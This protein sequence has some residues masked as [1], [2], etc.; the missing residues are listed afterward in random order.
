[1]AVILS[2]PQC[3]KGPVVRDNFVVDWQLSNK[4]AIHNKFIKSPV[5]Y[6]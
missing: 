5:K 4:Q 3:V 6:I 2:R 1:M